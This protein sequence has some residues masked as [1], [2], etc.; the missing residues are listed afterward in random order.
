MEERFTLEYRACEVDTDCVLALN[1]CCD[2]ANGGRDIAIARDQAAAFNARFACTGACTER[3]GDCGRG[4]I[5]C[6]GKLCVY[7]PPRE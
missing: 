3:G 7:H 6:E 4:T 2:C 5:A 1:G